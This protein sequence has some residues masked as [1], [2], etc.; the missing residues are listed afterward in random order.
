MGKKKRYKKLKMENK[1]LLEGIHVLVFRP[2]STDAFIIKKKY[3]FLRDIEEAVMKGD[4]TKTI[5]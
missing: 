5:S 2:Q 4:I 3:K 1:I